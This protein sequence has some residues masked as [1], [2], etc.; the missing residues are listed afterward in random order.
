MLCKKNRITSC[1]YTI[2]AGTQHNA[3]SYSHIKDGKYLVLASFYS[4]QWYSL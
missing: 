4:Q 2:V 1:A 3:N